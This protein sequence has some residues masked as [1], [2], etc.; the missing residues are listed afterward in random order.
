M[1]SFWGKAPDGNPGDS[2]PILQSPGPEV[3][4]AVSLTCTL[5]GTGTEV[6]NNGLSLAHSVLAWY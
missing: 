1:T 2:E 6:G 5:G 3:T 4:P